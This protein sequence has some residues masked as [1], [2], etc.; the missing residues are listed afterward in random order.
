MK[1]CVQFQSNMLYFIG[2]ELYPED[3]D[4]TGE[5]KPSLTTNK[6]IEDTL[7]EATRLHR[8]VIRDLNNV[9]VHVNVPPKCKHVNPLPLDT[10]KTA[11]CNSRL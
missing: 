4:F 9:A 7:K 3:P 5:R 1:H 11:D 10:G 2:D 8:I 6:K